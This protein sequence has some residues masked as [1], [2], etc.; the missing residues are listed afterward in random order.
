MTKINPLFE[1]LG[2]IDDEIAANAIK[3]AEQRKRKKPLKIIL[4]SAAAAAALAVTLIVGFVI[5]GTGVHKITYSVRGE[6]REIVLELT[7]Y[8]LTIPEEVTLPL[9][10]DDP[11]YG[12]ENFD[13]AR[14]MFDKLGIEPFMNEN[15]ELSGNYARFD[16]FQLGNPSLGI[17]E[18]EL[19]YWLFDKNLG[20]DVSFSATYYS[21]TKHCGSEL[22]Y[23]PLDGEKYEVLTLNDGSQCL[24]T[25]RQ[26]GFAYDGI[27][28]NFSL[29]K[30]FSP[31]KETSDIND[32]KQVLADLGVL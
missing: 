27:R 25:Y 14:E 10:V 29:D 32:M 31:D 7:P 17:L 21:E 22:A 13:T 24:V 30:E 12:S 8:E 4:I 1:A 16:I 23:P 5:V 2:N 28:F 15:F 19:T 6:Q 11:H 9:S 3:T 26:A 18:T 20:K